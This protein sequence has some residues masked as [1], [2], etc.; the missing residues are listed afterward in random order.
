MRNSNRLTPAR[1][2]LAIRP[3]GWRKVGAALM[4]VTLVTW[5]FYPEDLSVIPQLVGEQAVLC[6]A[7]SG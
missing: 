5:S 1:V 6:C 4:Y 7:F 2:P 3:C